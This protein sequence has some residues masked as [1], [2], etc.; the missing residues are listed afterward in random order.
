MSIR[1]F[2]IR[3]KLA[4][5]SRLGPHVLRELLSDERLAP[6]LIA[7]DGDLGRAIR[8]HEYNTRLGQALYADLQGVEVILRNALSR[9]LTTHFARTDWYDEPVLCQHHPHLKAVSGAKSR[10][11]REGKPLTSGRIVAE[12]SFGFWVGLTGP[13]HSRNGLWNRALYKAF[14]NARLQRAGCH[15]AL[16]RLRKLRNRIAHHE[17]VFARDSRTDGATMIDVLGW[18]DPIA[19]L[20]LIS[21]SRLSRVAR[22]RPRS[23]GWNRTTRLLALMRARFPRPD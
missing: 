22:S 9:V 17:P 11:L 12:L 13:A 3:E 19:V 5:A 14:P 7:A 8:L 18:I 6:Y 1:R 23:P 2:T 16:D 10:L 15:M 20:W 21:N 4:L